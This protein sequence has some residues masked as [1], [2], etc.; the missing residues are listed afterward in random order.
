MGWEGRRTLGTSR[1]PPARDLGDGDA[2]ALPPEVLS[3]RVSVTAVTAAGSRRI[4]RGALPRLEEMDDCAPLELMMS[5][6]RAGETFFPAPICPRDSTVVVV[7]RVVGACRGCQALCAVTRGGER[8]IRL[9]RVWR[10]V[11]WCARELSNTRRE[12]GGGEGH[13]GPH[14]SVVD[15]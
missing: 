8:A 10:V 15:I 3:V 12:A 2:E 7:C 4:R 9:C 13:E 14:A 5:R 11:D 1:P 6:G